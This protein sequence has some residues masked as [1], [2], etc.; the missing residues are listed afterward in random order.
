M[1]ETKIRQMPLCWNK[2]EVNNGHPPFFYFQPRCQWLWVP[3]STG[4]LEW[5][6]KSKVASTTKNPSSTEAPRFGVS[7]PIRAGELNA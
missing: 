1:M 5:N 6:E 3:V 2:K 7:V 4:S